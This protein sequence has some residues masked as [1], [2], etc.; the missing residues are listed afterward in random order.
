VPE[1]LL[2]ITRDLAA[3][4]GETVCVGAASGMNVVFL[5]VI[6]SRERV[7][8]AAEVGQRIPIHA[9]ASGQAIMSQWTAN[10]RNAILRKVQFE[11]YGE[12]T[13]MSIEAVEDQLRAGLHRGWFRSASN[14]SVD[15]GGVALPIVTSGRVFSLTVGAPIHRIESIM[16]ETACLAH[17]VVGDHLGASFLK[18]EVRDLA[19][20][21]VNRS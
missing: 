20:P 8:Y 10:Q 19:S 9:T 4:T 7:R 1:P 14:Y 17:E 16:Y 18:S 15:L 5:E 12:G 6:Q 21:P 3:K 2:R 11:R 13:P